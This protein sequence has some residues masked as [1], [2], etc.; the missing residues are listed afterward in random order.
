MPQTIA[1]AQQNASLGE[2]GPIAIPGYSLREEIGRGGMGIVYRATDLGFD[3]DVA[4]K[5]LGDKVA[6]D[7]S[8]QSGFATRRESP[9]NGSIREVPPRMSWACLPT[10]NRFWR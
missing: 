2:F 7:S 1:A 5:L 4:I 6:A 3:R 9:A 8:P 10:A